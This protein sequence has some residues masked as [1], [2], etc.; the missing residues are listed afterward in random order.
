M[1][2]LLS[3][4]CHPNLFPSKLRAFLVEF[5][6]WKKIPNR[7]LGF[8][9]SSRELERRLVMDSLLGLRILTIY[10]ERELKEGTTGEMWSP[11]GKDFSSGITDFATLIIS[12]A[13]FFCKLRDSEIAFRMS[14]SEVRFYS[15]GFGALSR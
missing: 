2:S 7:N 14:W 10:I 3:L 1:V 4:H 8:A 9:A 11:G 13:N 12:H 5:A 15:I 6:Q